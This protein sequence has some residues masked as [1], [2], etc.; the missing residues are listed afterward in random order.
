ML[1][2]SLKR[3]PRTFLCAVSILFGVGVAAAAD[4][5]TPFITGQTPG[6]VRNNFTGLAGIKFT[7]GATPITVYS[8]GR[9]YVPGNTM[10]HFLD[11]VQASNGGD[12][13]GGVASVNMSLSPQIGAYKYAPLSSP[14]TLQANTSYYLVGQ[15]Q[16]GG[17]QFYDYGPVTSTN[18]GTVNGPAYQDQNGTFVP[19][20]VPG[21]AYVPVNFTYT[22]QSSSL[23]ATITS[24]QNGDPISGSFV[25]IN[26]NST[27]PVSSVQVQVD[28]NN[29]GNPF[30]GLQ[31]PFTYFLD[32]TTLTNG[33]HILTATVSDSQGHSA[34]SPPVSV[35]VTNATPGGST[36]FITGQTPGAVRNNFSG[37]V[38]MRFTVGPTPLSVTALG[39][40]YLPG[41]SGTHTLKIVR[42]SNNTDVPGGSATVSL[43][44]GDTPNTY[45]YA[46]LANPINLLPN[47]SYY[48]LSLEQAGGDT[49]YDSGPVTITPGAGAVNGPAYQDA[50]GVYNSLSLPGQAYGPVNLVYG[51]E[52]STLSVTINPLPQIISGRGNVAVSTSGPVQSV[53]LQVDGQSVGVPSTVPPYLLVFDTT[54]ISN[55]IHT[56]TAVASDGQGQTVT[57]APLQVTVSNSPSGASTPF[58]TSQTP[59][60]LRNNFTGFVGMAFTVG[61]TPIRINSLGRYVVPGNSMT[62]TVKLVQASTGAE[63]ASVSIPLTGATPNQ[64]AYGLLTFPTFLQAN[65]TYYL[66]SSETTGGDQWYDRGPVSST[67]V[68]KVTG[69]AYQVGNGPYNVI[70]FFSN[71][72]YGPVNFSYQP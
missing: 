7:V 11:L 66:L 59:G 22:L 33:S 17:D 53:Q 2:K 15:E 37:F 54:A 61:P 41:N 63:L 46:F 42:A 30:L 34:T 9:I 44:G 26:I 60:A 55:G 70:T 62:H 48:L 35:T 24:P 68:A 71:Q 4:T 65:T 64:Y 1:S 25:P 5:P 21:Q 32:T 19:V 27:G 51:T 10:T 56:L 14:V 8:L 18:A 52:S 36:A 49:W 50:R 40:I 39:R 38:G 23:S 67:G 13:P 6:N 57:S 69:P 43:A 16:S 28:G 45:K 3:G 72:D 29:V 12:V 20:N 47:T 31:P 58:I